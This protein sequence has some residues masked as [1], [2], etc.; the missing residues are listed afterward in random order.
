MFLNM[1]GSAK[2][3]CNRRAR[4]TQTFDGFASVQACKPMAA[5][6]VE[7]IRFVDAHQPGFVE[8]SITDARGVKHLFI[9]K[10]PVVTLEYLTEN[11]SYP[12]R[13]TIQCILVRQWSDSEGREMAS[14][15][16]GEPWGIESSDGQTRFNVLISQLTAL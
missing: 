2:V 1:F 13:G 14:I 6:D 11:S 7:I 15:D 4:S 10:V 5:L 16:T 12:R 8:C 3:E 9:E